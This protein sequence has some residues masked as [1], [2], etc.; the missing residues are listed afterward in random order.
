MINSIFFSKPEFLWLLLLLP[1]VI[2]AHFFFLFKTQKKALLFANFE[3]LRRVDGKRHVVRNTPVLIL[4]LFILLLLIISLSGVTVYYDGLRS[5]SDYVLAI[6]TSASML[7][8]DLTPSRFVVAKQG[9]ITFINSLSSQTKVGLVSFS[10]VTKILSPLSFN[11]LDTHVNI[12]LLN[13]SAL[14]GTDITGAIVTGTNLLISSNNSRSLII[15]TDGIDTMGSF[16]DNSIKQAVAYALENDVVINTVGL[17]SNSAPVGYLPEIYNLKSSLDKKTLAYIANQTG[18][19]VLFPK[20]SQDLLIG[21]KR[22][23]SGTHKAS[24][25]FSLEKYGVLFSLLFLLIEWVFINLRFRRV[26]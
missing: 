16:I 23:S 15:F 4:R 17:G 21:L 3:A 22:L 20:T 19:V 6:D 2:F 8:K 5:N 25:S 7:T 18:G 1:A 11:H 26:A 13:I 10:G 24:L 9:A 12:G 14:S